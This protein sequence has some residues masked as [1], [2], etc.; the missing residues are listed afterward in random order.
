[1]YGFEKCM[2]LCQDWHKPQLGY[3]ENYMLYG[4]YSA[5]GTFMK[6]R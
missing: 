4:C 5:D 6:D 1:M 3:W 2:G